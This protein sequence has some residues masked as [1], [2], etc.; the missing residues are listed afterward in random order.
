MHI[1]NKSIVDAALI[2]FGEFGYSA[3]EA[4]AVA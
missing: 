4:G 2:L 3:E 1:I